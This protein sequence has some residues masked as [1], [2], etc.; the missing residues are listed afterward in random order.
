MLYSAKINVQF[1]YRVRSFASRV[2]P[3]DSAATEPLQV[4]SSLS[5]QSYISYFTS[6]SHPQVVSYGLAGHYEPHYD[7]FDT[8]DTFIPRP[9]QQ[10]Q[11]QYPA[12]CHL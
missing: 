3:L 4:S 2:S 8:M 11:V 1:L 7:Y 9:G 5:S 6:L 10:E 12:T